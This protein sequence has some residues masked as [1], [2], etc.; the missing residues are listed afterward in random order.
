[1]LGEFTAML[2][3][4]NPVS[5]DASGTTAS[6]TEQASGRHAGDA[7]ST[8]LYECDSC[9]EVFIAEEKQHCADCEAGVARVDETF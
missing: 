9:G 7:G 5:N 2:G 3:R 8:H 6:D 1:M 4:L